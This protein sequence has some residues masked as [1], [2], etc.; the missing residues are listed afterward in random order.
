[1]F[2]LTVSMFSTRRVGLTILVLRRCLPGMSLIGGDFGD[3]SGGGDAPADNLRCRCDDL[4]RRAEVIAP[5]APLSLCDRTSNEHRMVNERLRIA[6][7]IRALR[8]LPS[9]QREAYF[10]VVA[11]IDV[12][13]YFA[14]GRL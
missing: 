11:R 12:E 4:Y 7:Q 10:V 1:V 2:L 9:L 8:D 14:V 5:A 6:A 3:V 13:A